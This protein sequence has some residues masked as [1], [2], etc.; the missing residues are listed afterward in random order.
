[1]WSIV[2]IT[3]GVW[4]GMDYRTGL[5]GPGPGPGPGPGAH[6]LRGPLSQSLCAVMYLLFVVERGVFCEFAVGFN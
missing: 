5:L 1:M 3:C 2:Y 6:E 4:Q